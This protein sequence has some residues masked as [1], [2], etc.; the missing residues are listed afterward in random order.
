MGCTVYVGD[1]NMCLVCV[2]K[3]LYSLNLYCLYCDVIAMCSFVPLLIY[4]HGYVYSTYIDT[5]LY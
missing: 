2:M 3:Y 1:L 5:F 4:Y